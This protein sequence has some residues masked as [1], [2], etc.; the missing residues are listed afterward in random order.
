[1]I[2]REFYVDEICYVLELT[3]DHEIRFFID[4]PKSRHIDY[5][6]TLYDE[7]APWGTEIRPVISLSLDM[8]NTKIEH[9]FQIK[10]IMIKFVEEVAKRGVKHFSF[11]ANE[12][13]KLNLYRKIAEKVAEEFGYFLYEIENSFQFYKR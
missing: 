3:H 2:K 10:T 6:M 7:L 9:F 4:V 11:G 8:V 5:P 1:M 13:R 12:Y